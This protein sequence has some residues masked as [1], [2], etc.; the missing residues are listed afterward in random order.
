MAM[1]GR[2]WGDVPDIGKEWV[3]ADP[4]IR[5]IDSYWFPFEK[6]IPS[7]NEKPNA[8]MRI[9]WAQRDAL[10][11]VFTVTA[12]GANNRIT[13]GSKALL[14][15]L[16]AGDVLYSAAAGDA[17][18]MIVDQ[19]DRTNFY[20]YAYNIAG[21]DHVGTATDY[22]AGNILYSAG[23]SQ[24]EGGRAGV[25]QYDYTAVYNYQQSFGVEITESDL[26]KITNFRVDED[27]NLR[28]NAVREFW[29]RIELAL[30]LGYRGTSAGVGSYE[31]SDG[32]HYLTGGFKYYIDDAS[33]NKTIPLVNF[34]GADGLKL[35]KDFLKDAL[36]FG[37]NKSHWCICGN[38]FYVELHNL[39]EAKNIQFTPTS[40]EFDVFNIRT[41]MGKTLNVVVHPGLTNAFAYSAYFFD[42]NEVAMSVGQPMVMK[43]IDYG[44]YN[45][46]GYKLWTV[47]GLKPYTSNTLY[48]LTLT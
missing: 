13:V 25:V 24:A 26:H 35:W 12:H 38:E 42:S 1:E 14:H 30:L 45:K 21:T 33:Q 47:K 46:T 18:W 6:F 27:G 2:K 22:V 9:D 23:I 8:S 31:P 41:F 32:T 3:S 19:I 36:K 37:S 4:I 10:P 34:T 11:L 20:I 5:S 7:I 17:E 40:L 39:Y 44:R 16:H 43:E 48:S 29:K 28:Q 15:G